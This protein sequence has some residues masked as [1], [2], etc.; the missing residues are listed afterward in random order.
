MKLAVFDNHVR[1]DSGLVRRRSGGTSALSKRNRWEGE[2][3][4]KSYGLAPQ[5]RVAATKSGNPRLV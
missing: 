1:L 5:L 3:S 4:K 2:V